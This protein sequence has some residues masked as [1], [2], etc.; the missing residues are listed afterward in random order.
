MSEKRCLKVYGLCQKLFLVASEEESFHFHVKKLVKKIYHGTCTQQSFIRG[1]SDPRSNPWPFYK[2]F[3]T[4]KGTPVIYLLLTN[5]IPFTYLI[6][7]FASL[8]TAVN[9]L[10]S[11]TWINPHKTRTFSRLFHRDKMHL[12]TLLCPF[13]DRNNRFPYPFIF[14][15]KCNPY[16]F[17]YLNREKGTPFAQSLPE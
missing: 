11:K 13:T 4:K 8:S 14:F 15:N 17:I 3:L 6:K 2:L 7:N 5:G 9:A 1:G 16:T 10:S 12:V